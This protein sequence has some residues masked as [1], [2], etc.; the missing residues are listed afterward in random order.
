MLSG[1][2]ALYRKAGL[3][4]AAYPAFR[5]AVVALREGIL[6]PYQNEAARLNRPMVERVLSRCTQQVDEED[7]GNV[8]AL[9]GLLRR[10]AVEAARDEARTFC[11]DLVARPAMPTY[12]RAAA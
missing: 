9:L 11:H 6:P 4:D 8:E 1:F 12:R 5:E 10:F 7:A 3:P 2:R